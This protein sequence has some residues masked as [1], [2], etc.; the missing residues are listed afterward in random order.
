MQRAVAGPDSTTPPA[1]GPLSDT[2]L[3]I[4]AILSFAL[5]FALVSRRLTS[6]W[7]SA[8]MVFVAFGLATGELGLGWL[9]VELERES[10][11]LLAELTL[12]LV[13]FGDA[14]RISLRAL[15]QEAGLPVRLLGLGMPLTILLGTGLAIALFPSL[16]MWEAATLAAVLA[17]TDAALGQAVVSHP[18][19]PLRVRQA[20]NVEGG[21]NDGIA[22][23]VVLVFAALATSSS[24]SADH[25]LR[26]WLLQVTLGPLVGVVL[27]WAGAQALSAASQ[28]R[29]MDDTWERVGAL[30]LAFLAYTAA[31]AVGG[32]GFM[33]AFTAGLTVGHTARDVVACVHEF[34]EAEGQ[35]L[36]L[37]VFIVLGAFLV[38]P[39]LGRMTP[40]MLGYAVASL[41]VV[42]AVPVAL[43]M[44]GIGAS[45]WTILFLGWFGPRGLASVIFG[46]LVLDEVGL[47]HGELVFD[48]VCITVF[49]SVVLHG[50]TATWGAERYGA[51]VEDVEGMEHQPVT[52]HPTR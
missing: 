47:P 14:S 48:V 4:L 27:G 15:R 34:L 32:N 33:A 13:L 35:L 41:T 1:G 16:S 5:A 43:S 18:S 19:V 7:L 31:E 20:L 23:P 29:W 21:L 24:H 37:A 25:W 28:H 45:R 10:M 22:L 12:V 51:Y 2:A 52:H 26:F 39:S 36:M 30:A 46:L 42:R 40:A 50:V 17:P 6:R 3:A 9:D 44:L 49:A 8:P 11:A 38:P